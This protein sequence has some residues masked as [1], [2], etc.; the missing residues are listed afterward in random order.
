MRRILLIALLLLLGLLP[1]KAQ[2]FSLADILIQS[3]SAESAELTLLLF[4]ISEADPALLTRLSVPDA[5]LTILAPS[6][7]AFVEFM[8]TYNLSLSDLVANPVMLNEIVRYHI[9]DD[10][11]SSAEISAGESLTTLLPDNTIL[12]TI[13]RNNVRL[14]ASSQIVRDGFEANNGILHLID[15]VLL[16]QT[17]LNSLLGI[18]NTPEVANRTIVEI[19]QSREELSTFA[20]ALERNGLLETLSDTSQN[21][22]LFAPT[23]AAFEALELSTE[24]LTVEMLL[25]HAFDNALDSSDFVNQPTM[26]TLQGAEIEVTM[27]EEGLLLNGTALVLEANIVASNGVLHIID[28]VLLIPAEA[29]PEATE[30]S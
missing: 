7:E 29:T 20:L 25:Y 26:T 2:D 6:D 10:K 5:N 1:L 27:T 11:L 13:Q 23:N 14:N 12:V 3:A 9:L 4:A 8:R 19:L 21:F 22:T 24:N 18:A 17:A 16:P 30:G 15:E 28:E